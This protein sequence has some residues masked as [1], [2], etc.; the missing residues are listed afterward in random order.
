M[1]EW[2]TVCFTGLFS[3]SVMVPGGVA[4]V[5]DPH[6]WVTSIVICICVN[7]DTRIDPVHWSD[8]RNR[9]DSSR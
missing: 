7:M 8:H 1:E 2:K 5:N 3:A 9:Q 6:E 4:L